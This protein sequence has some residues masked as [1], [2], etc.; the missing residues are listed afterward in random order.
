MNGFAQTEKGKTMSSC[1]WC[2]YMCFG[3]AP[4]CSMKQKVLAESTIKSYSCKDFAECEID[5]ITLMERKERRVKRND[6]EQEVMR[7]E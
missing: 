1:R 6:G 3:D 2:A 7:F 4:W 5:A